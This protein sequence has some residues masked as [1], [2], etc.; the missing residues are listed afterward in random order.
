MRPPSLAFG[1]VGGDEGLEIGADDPKPTLP[2]ADLST[3]TFDDEGQPRKHTRRGVERIATSK[4]KRRV[5]IEDDEDDDPTPIFDDE[6][7]I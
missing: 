2:N 7:P 3:S 1:E 6:L 4:N 5:I